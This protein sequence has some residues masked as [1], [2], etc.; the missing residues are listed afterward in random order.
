M[1]MRLFG[2]VNWRDV[3]KSTLTL[4]RSAPYAERTAAWFARTAPRAAIADGAFCRAR[5]IASSRVI[6]IAESAGTKRATA[7]VE[8]EGSD[9]GVC[10]AMRDAEATS[11]AAS[12]TKDAPIEARERMLKR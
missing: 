2:S 3:P 8:S 11:A 9:T 7:A 4:G 12:A 10:A 1:R 5:R 6:G